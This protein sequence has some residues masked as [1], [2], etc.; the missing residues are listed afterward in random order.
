MAEMIERKKVVTSIV[1]KIIQEITRGIL[2][3]GERLPSIKE[4]SKQFKVSSSSIREALQQLEVLGLVNIQQGKG[5]FINKDLS[6]NS[7]ITPLKSL[8]ILKKPVFQELLQVRKVIEKETV[9]LASKNADQKD[10]NELYETLEAMGEAKRSGNI[11][12][13]V[14][15]DI[16]FHSLI[17][18]ASKNSF[19]P[20]ILA[21]VHGTFIE[22]QEFVASLP[23]ALEKAYEYHRKIYEAIK[24]KNPKES[25]RQMLAHLT[26][27][28][29]IIKEYY[30]EIEESYPDALE[31][32]SQKDKNE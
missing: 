7:L 27:I 32:F 16:K 14:T 26:S 10:I 2:K 5:S 18:K 15:Q 23:G 9:F 8:I 20:S 28:E 31:A 17:A 21:V 29:R 13:F 25:R 1:E 22:Q 24:S 3:P 4:L 12:E 11:K 6:A 30:K 19:F